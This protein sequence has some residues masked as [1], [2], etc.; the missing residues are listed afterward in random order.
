MKT[1]DEILD[2]KYLS[3]K[4]IQVITGIGINASRD[5]VK[6]IKDISTQKGYYQPPVKKLICLTK[7]ARKF[8]G[9]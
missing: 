3:A 6:K 5:L 9:I 4:D 1:T 7:E 2:Q 8:L